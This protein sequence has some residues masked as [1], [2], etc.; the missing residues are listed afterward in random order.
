M[1]AIARV[2][3]NP[4]YKPSKWGAIFHAL[5]HDEAL[6]AGAAGPGKSFVLLMDPIHQVMVE[7]ER[8]IRTDHPHWQPWGHSTGWAL[9][10]RRT[11]PMLDQTIMRSH[12]IF[13][14]I[15]PGAKWYSDKTTWVFSS[16]YRYQF[17]HCMNPNSWEG[18]MSAEFSWI[19]FD[20][21]IQFEEEQYV[22]ISG[23]CRSADPVLRP[24]KKVRCC[25]N[26]VMSRQNNER[27]SVSNPQWVRKYFV[28]PA[29]EGKVT[30]RKNITLRD[31][32]KDSLTRIYLPATLYD[33]PDPAFV[34][35]YERT[36]LGKPPHVVKALLYG[37]WYVTPD[38]YYGEAWDPRYHVCEGFKIPSHWPMFRSMDWGY[39]NPGTIVWWAM[40]P[41]GNLYGVRELTFQGMPDEEVAERVKAT[42]I[43]LGVWDAHTG[44]KLTGPADDQLWERR[45][46]S[47][48]SKAA[49]F[50]EKG[51]PWV[52]ADKR[53]R[54]SNA[55]RL[56]KRLK[57]HAG[58][59]TTAGLVF[60]DECRMCIQTIPAI[61]SVAG[62]AEMPA[63]GGDDHW[64]DATLYAM[65][66]ASRGREGIPTRSDDDDDGFDRRVGSDR[67]RYGYGIVL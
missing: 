8:C 66:Y 20:E 14:Q 54:A 50:L 16:G 18:Y 62:D 24:M 32:T 13:P 41:D 19:G 40:D 31:G 7:H 10:L 28:D 33:N 57:D 4:Y 26:P 63:D 6:G 21:V 52:K 67:G 58:E 56:L 59:G 15:D 11:R 43:A 44:S 37:D 64:H 45:G 5:P 61:Q 53:S 60:F 51:V 49:V 30:I 55:Q 1:A 12:R 48:K 35:D 9:H 47:S 3:P 38:S 39:K 65:A 17:G 29:P 34:R 23:R 22:Q 36:L 27:V 25:T 2:D 46:D 42:E